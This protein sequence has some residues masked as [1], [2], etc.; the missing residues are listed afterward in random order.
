MIT[1]S[2]TAISNA[3]ASPPLADS[4][5]SPIENCNCQLNIVISQIDTYL[6]EQIFEHNKSWP[7]FRFEQPTLCHQVKYFIWTIFRSCKTFTIAEFLQYLY[8]QAKIDSNRTQLTSGPRNPHH[9]SSPYVNISQSVT[10][11]D[12]TSDACENC[13]RRNDSGGHLKFCWSMS[14]NFNSLTMQM[15]PFSVPTSHSARQCPVSRASDQNRLFLCAK[16]E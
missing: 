14:A 12:Q 2:F 11:N 4:R 15:E 8:T 7:T 16:N 13:R 3:F 6:V 1:L 10:P 5:H 9:G